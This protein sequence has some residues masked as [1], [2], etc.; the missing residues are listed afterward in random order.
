[1]RYP[2]YRDRLPP[3]CAQI[4]DAEPDEGFLAGFH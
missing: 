2:D 3:R 4:M 1:M